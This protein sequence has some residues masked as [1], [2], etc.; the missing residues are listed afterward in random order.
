MNGVI[1]YSDALKMDEDEIIEANAA[2][3][4]FIESAQ[5]GGK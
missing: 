5:K 3:D 1:G 4:V 2:L